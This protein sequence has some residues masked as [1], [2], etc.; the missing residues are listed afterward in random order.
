ML[1]INKCQK[2]NGKIIKMMIITKK[3]HGQEIE[4]IMIIRQIIRKGTT[5]ITMMVIEN[6]EMTITMKIG[7]E[8]NGMMIEIVIDK[9]IDLVNNG[10][11]KIPINHEIN[12]TETKMTKIQ[13]NIEQGNNGMMKAILISDP[14]NNGIETRIN[15]NK[16]N[17]GI[18]IIMIM[19]TMNHK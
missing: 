6:N 1:N 12:G 8:N 3:N 5:M 18:E 9:S 17:N 11:V 16:K 19:I 2:N 7:L 13:N 4:A 10:I 14:K 15:I